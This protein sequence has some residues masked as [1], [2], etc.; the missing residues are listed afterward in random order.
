MPE[1]GT[2]VVLVHGGYHG[3]WCWEH[4]LPHVQAP[5]IAVDLPGR[6]GRPAPIDEVTLD[7]WVDAVLEDAERAGFDRFTLVGHSL[8]GVTITELAYRHPHRVAALVYVAGLVPGVGESAADLAPDRPRDQLLPPEE[9]IRE[10]SGTGMDEESFVRLR[11]RLVPDAP[12]PYSQPIS[13]HPTGI[14][15]TYVAM[16]SDK[17]VPPSACE[18]MAARLGPAVDY[19]VI[20]GAGHTVMQTHP[21]ELAAIINAVS[22]DVAASEERTQSGTA[23]G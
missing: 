18:Q 17:A 1:S 8:G 10:Y 23:G 22:G 21:Q 7:D 6:P 20:E 3:A 14:P 4:L 9:A 11:D 2:P 15:R 13:G 12:G 5:V 16:E 19:H